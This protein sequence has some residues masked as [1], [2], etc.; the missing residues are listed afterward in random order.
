MRVSIGQDSH[1]FNE[2]KQGETCILGGVAFDTAPAFD[3]NSDGEI[4]IADVVEIANSVMGN[5]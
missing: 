4:S 5:K 3:A 1:R 2:E